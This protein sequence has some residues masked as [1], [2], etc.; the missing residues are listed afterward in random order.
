[1][2]A[3]ENKVCFTMLR[4]EHA[5]TAFITQVGN[6]LTTGEGGYCNLGALLIP[7]EDAAVIRDRAV[8]TK[9]P[10]SLPVHFISIRYLG[11][12]SE[13]RLG[14]EREQ[15][16]DAEIESLLD[17]VPVEDTMLPRPVADKVGSIIGSLKYE[18]KGCLLRRGRRQFDLNGQSHG[19]DTMIQHESTLVSNSM[20]NAQ[21]FLPST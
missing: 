2:I 18:E 21:V 4:E 8:R 10:L 19:D 5:S 11:D 6:T 15:V 17:R 3:P 1:L 13:D 16:L 9:Y 20:D 7:V 12:H 14:G